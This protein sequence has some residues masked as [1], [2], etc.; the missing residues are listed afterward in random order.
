MDRR[1][2][3]DRPPGFPFNL[4]IVVD[5]LLKKEF[6]EY[7]ERGKPHPY[8][9]KAGIDAV[10]AQHSMLNVWRE[11][12]KGVQY[13]HE[14]TNL[15]I[16]GA[17]DDLWIGSD[18]RYIVVDYKAT[19][20]AGEVSLD[21]DWQISYKR[22]ME[23]YQWLLRMNGL[24]V[25]PTGWFVYC[26]GSRDASGFEEQLIFK[27]SLI[28]YT[29]DD[30][31]VEGAVYDAWDTLRQDELPFPDEDCDF[32]AYRSDAQAIEAASSP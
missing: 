7:R 25:D 22:Q 15:I 14:P 9:T 21:A 29:G 8:M 11:N 28:P 4:N 23:I 31:W 18:Q 30:G 16:T 20:K 3:V 19:S 2:G 32:C 17:I 1:L 12:F 10:P 26:N 24:D 13:H 5:T 27:V 6:D